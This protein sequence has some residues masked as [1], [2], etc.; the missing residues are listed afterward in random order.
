MNTQKDNL[1]KFDELLV[2]ILEIPKSDI[3]DKL[4]PDDVKTWD[5][6]NG[7]LIASELESLFGLRFTIEDISGV[8]N[9][10]DMKRVLRKYNIE[11]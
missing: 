11:I 7:L 6:F 3:N 9:V 5:S 1:K 2:R 4:S 10:G 8:K